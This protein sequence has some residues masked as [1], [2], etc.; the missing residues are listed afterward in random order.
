[1]PR[2]RTGPDSVVI[3][4]HCWIWASAGEE[5]MKDWA[6]YRGRF[7]LAAISV[8]E[9]GMLCRKGRLELKPGVE[10]WVEENLAPPVYLQALTP[11]IALQAA[12]LEDFHGD[13]AD[14]IIT[15]TALVL[16]QSLVTADAK[17]IE[18]FRVR[19]ELSGRVKPV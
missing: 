17:I 19:P 12:A 15:A 16:E 2:T 11:A 1:M 10:Q 9:V 7:T 14:R 3:D 18:W 5:R 4:T 8:W 6:G 13:P